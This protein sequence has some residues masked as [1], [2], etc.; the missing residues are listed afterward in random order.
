[1][2]KFNKQTNTLLKTIK[3]PKKR[4][5]ER[6]SNKSWTLDYVKTPLE[7]QNQ[8]KDTSVKK[9]VPPPSCHQP[10][11]KVRNDTLIKSDN[12][13]ELIDVPRNEN[14]EPT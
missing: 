14:Y 2:D 10:L 12:K 5:R 6:E 8:S 4:K 13:T 9:E 7:F 3:Y 11:T 1:M